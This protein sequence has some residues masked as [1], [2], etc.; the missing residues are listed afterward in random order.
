MRRAVLGSTPGGIYE[1]S[2]VLDLLHDAPGIKVVQKLGAS[3]ISPR[4]GR[5]IVDP[6]DG[7]AGSIRNRLEVKA[8][9][10]PP[11]LSGY[12]GRAVIFGAT[13]H[14]TGPRF[15]ALSLDQQTTETIK[16]ERRELYDSLGMACPD[17]KFCPHVTLLETRDQL[18]ADN[19]RDQ[20][21]DMEIKGMP[22]EFGK[23]DVITIRNLR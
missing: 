15:I 23:A 18:L 3:L 6:W 5:Q 8:L 21:N 13:R 19:L 12:I 9:T 1:R 16:Q 10:L 4:E 7:K 14:K 22:V 20:F 17:W 11:Q 2:K